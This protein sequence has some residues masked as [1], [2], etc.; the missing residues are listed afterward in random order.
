[1]LQSQSI[2]IVAFSVAACAFVVANGIWAQQPSQPNSGATS[3]DQPAGRAVTSDEAAKAK[4]M[5][6]PAWRQA[7]EEF[8]KWLESQAIYTPE[9]VARIKA[10]QLAQIRAMPASELQGFLDD[11]QARLKVLNGQDFQ[12]AQQWLGEF[13]SVMVDGF[14]RQTLKDLG[15]TDVANMSAAQLEDA[16]IR[17]RAERLSRQANRAAFELQRQQMSQQIQQMNAVR[18]LA[19]PQRNATAA[20]FATHQSP[21]RPPRFDPPPP[22]RQQFFVDGNGRVGFLLPY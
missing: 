6:S 15:L 21:Y 2:R 19:Q 12:E 8:Q 14:R 20:R 18:Q 22:R 13:M 17:I 7:N 10:K 4:I 5:A 1:M 11:W 16:I 3:S 9:D